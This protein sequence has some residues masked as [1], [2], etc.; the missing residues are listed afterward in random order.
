MGPLLFL[1]YINDL[2]EGLITNAKLFADDTSLFSVVRDIAASTEKLNKD[3]RNIGKWAYRWKMI[4][5]P[6]LTK[7]AQEVIFSRKLNKLVP[8]F[9]NSQ[10]SQTKTQ[11]HLGLILDNKLNFNE[12]LK[13]VLD[14]ISKTMGLVRKFQ[15]IL[16]RFSLLTIYKTFVNHILIMGT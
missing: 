3:L 12:H 5:N 1:I 7:Q 9:N 4:F 13:D 11:K 8:P 2:P 14:K 6:D 10:V 15:L 16:P